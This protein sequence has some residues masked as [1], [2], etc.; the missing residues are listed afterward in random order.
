MTWKDLPGLAKDIAVGADGTAWVI[1]AIAVNGGFTIHRWDGGNWPAVD[2]G[3]VRIA[4]APDGHPWVVN[5]AGQIYERVGDIWKIRPGS[6]KD[7]AVGA[8]GSVWVI[9][10]IPGNGGFTI[11]RW[12]GSDWDH[13]I[14]GYG[15]RIA[16]D[17][18]GRPWVVNDVHQIF[19]RIPARP[20]APEH[21][22]QQ[23]GLA[24]DVAISPHGQV[25][26]T[27]TDSVQYGHNVYWWAGDHWLVVDSDGGVAIAADPTDNPWVVDNRGII[28]EGIGIYPT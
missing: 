19:Q 3:A 23:P 25:W 18:L 12:N 1:G 15:V 24:T 14:D 17:H 22:Q 5:D 27:G 28:K 21:W 13:P 4:V 10:T 16:V 8:D 11:H 7:I 6:A 9:G 20:G 26:I 2:G